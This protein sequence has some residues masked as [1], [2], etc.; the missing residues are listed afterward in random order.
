MIIISLVTEKSDI[1]ELNTMDVLAIVDSGVVLGV[2]TLLYL[3]FYFEK[4]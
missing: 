4:R 2:L 3:L 1:I